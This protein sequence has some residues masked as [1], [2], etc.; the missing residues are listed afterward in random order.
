MHGEL[1]F[2]SVRQYGTVSARGSTCVGGG[3]DETHT[4]VRFIRS[5]NRR[6]QIGRCELCEQVEGGS[7]VGV[8]MRACAFLLIVI[9]A[10]VAEWSIATDCK[11]V[12]LRAT[13][14][15]ILP[16]A[17]K[18]VWH[19]DCARPLKIPFSSY[20]ALL[21]H[22]PERAEGMPWLGSEHDT[23]S[24]MDTVPTEREDS[25]AVE[26]FFDTRPRTDY[27]GVSATLP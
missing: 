9:H 16:G 17:Q 1:D 14:V 18:E 2:T 15:R 22:P 19:F 27:D 26:I 23:L 13:Q 5:A 7:E 8:P 25:P 20:L 4:A 6:E 11:S 3:V 24:P 21:K 10:S 12:A